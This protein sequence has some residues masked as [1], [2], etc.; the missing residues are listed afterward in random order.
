MPQLPSVFELINHPLQ[1]NVVLPS[2]PPQKLPP[3]EAVGATQPGH[4]IL[5]AS[6]SG[7][8]SSQ[9]GRVA[10]SRSNSDGSCQKAEYRNFQ[11]SPEVIKGGRRLT[12]PHIDYF[13]YYSQPRVS[14]SSSVAPLTR[15]SSQNSLSAGILNPSAFTRHNSVSGADYYDGIH[16]VGSSPH[17]AGNNGMATALTSSNISGNQASSLNSA[18]LTP[19]GLAAPPSYANNLTGQLH[20]STQMNVPVLQQDAS[21]IINSSSSPGSHVAGNAMMSSGIHGGRFSFSHTQPLYPPLNYQGAVSNPYSS[22]RLLV[23]QVDQPALVA[24]GNYEGS[25][26]SIQGQF[27]PAHSH[28]N[29]SNSSYEYSLVH[30]QVHQ[31]PL[32]YPLYRDIQYKADEN[33]AL[34]NKRRIIKRRTR[35]GCLTCRKRR[36]KCDERKPFCYNCERSKKVCL[37]YEDLTKVKKKKDRGK[38][39]ERGGEKESM[40]EL[41]VNKDGESKEAGVKEE[42][43]D[44]II[45]QDNNESLKDEGKHEKASLNHKDDRLKDDSIAKTKSDC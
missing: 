2:A 44:Y 41:K 26:A 6:S 1:N 12:N 4:S 3:S 28:L 43:H 20:H 7:S 31:T 42:H 39:G 11:T 32:Y 30:Y 40:E 8:Q 23:I 18:A 14:I 25:Q 9:A 36:I 37:G 5:L 22:Q 17:F 10:M 16:H 19:A 35:T 15:N 33:N 45:N 27:A 38:D 21:P 34:L 29:S 13:N 24:S